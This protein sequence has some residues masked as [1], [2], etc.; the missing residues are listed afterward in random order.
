MINA[1]VVLGQKKTYC[2]LAQV[3]IKRNCKDVKQ[4]KKSVKTIQSIEK[5]I[6]KNLI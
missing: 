3:E 5:A 6:Q 1:Q 2:K 4:L